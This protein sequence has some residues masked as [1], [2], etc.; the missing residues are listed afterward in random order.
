MNTNLLIAA[1]GLVLAAF[2]F[3]LGQKR[4]NIDDGQKLGEFMGEIRTD[5]RNIKDDINEMKKDRRATN[6][7]I[8]RAIQQHEERY[9]RTED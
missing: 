6:E 4:S 3:F 5:I 2:T 9:H 1:A 8:E 7:Q